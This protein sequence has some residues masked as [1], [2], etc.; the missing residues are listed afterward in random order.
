M[1]IFFLKSEILLFFIQIKI[2]KFTK[3]F[4]IVLFSEISISIMQW[5]CIRTQKVF[6]YD[7]CECVCICVWSIIIPSFG[8]CLSN[9]FFLY[10]F[11]QLTVRKREREREE[12]SI[13]TDRQI[14][15]EKYLIWPLYNDN[16]NNQNRSNQIS[17]VFFQ[18]SFN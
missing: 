7:Q 5:E 15:F 17:L 18:A 3:F 8:G 16:N 11:D 1:L 12:D 10:L 9:C 4:S 6:F 2:T 14:T 13:H